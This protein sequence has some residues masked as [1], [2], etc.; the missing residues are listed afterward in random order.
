MQMELDC[1]TVVDVE[2]PN[3]KPNSVCQIALIEVKQGQVVWK[4][5][6]L[7]NPEEPFDDFCIGVHGIKPETVKDAPTLKEV[8]PLIAPHYLEHV[9]V[10]HSASF[11]TA[12]M[13]KSLL[14]YGIYLPRTK[15]LCTYRLAL[16][17]YGYRGKNGKLVNRNSAKA[18]VSLPKG[19]SLDKLCDFNSIELIKHHNAADDAEACYELLLCLL[20]KCTLEQSD[21]HIYVQPDPS[22]PPK[23]RACMPLGGSGASYCLTGKFWYGTKKEVWEYIT[24]CGGNIHDDLHRNTDFLVIGGKGAGRSKL[25][26]AYK[27]IEDGYPLQIVDEPVMM[28]ALKG[29]RDNGGV[30]SSLF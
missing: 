16:K 18:G 17:L 12:M 1:Y 24:S 6:T 21:F 9:I 3:V 27:M 14:R 7:I 26:K 5:D 23:M 2:T 10:G 29:A 22:V 28:K 13:A 4:Y 20:D 19:L 30:Q 15:Y 25:S 11:D 8:W